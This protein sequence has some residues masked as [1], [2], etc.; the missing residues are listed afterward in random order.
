MLNHK[1][2][3]SPTTTVETPAATGAERATTTVTTK[4]GI[5]TTNQ[6][7]IKSKFM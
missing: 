3:T 4:A 6:Y 5:K 1:H 7:Q 2:I